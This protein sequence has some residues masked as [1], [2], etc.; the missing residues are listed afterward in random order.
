MIADSVRLVI[1]QRLLRKVCSNCAQPGENEML[2]AVGC[3][4]CNGQGYRGRLALHQ[5]WPLDDEMRVAMAAGCYGSV[6]QQAVSR[7][8]SFVM[9]ACAKQSRQYHRRRGASSTALIYFPDH[10][11]LL[12]ASYAAALSKEHDMS[13]PD[14]E[15]FRIKSGQTVVFAGDSITH[16]Y[17]GPEREDHP[18]GLGYCSMASRMMT[19]IY[20]TTN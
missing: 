12:T 5:C 19:R 1:G 11:S 13:W 3:E 10:C 9:K 20:L 6:L 17:G 4:Q 7:M 16:W 2:E 18:L 8:P 15:N 14:T